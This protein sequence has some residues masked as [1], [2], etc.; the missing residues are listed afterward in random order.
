MLNPP[1]LTIR[2]TRAFRGNGGER[3]TR[4]GSRQ[5]MG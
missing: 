4:S 1:M 3:G 5:A 2:T